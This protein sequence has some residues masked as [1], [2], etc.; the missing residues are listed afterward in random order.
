MPQLPPRMMR[1]GSRR[2]IVRLAI[3]SPDTVVGHLPK[4]PE[5]RKRFPESHTQSPPPFV[6]MGADIDQFLD[7]STNPS[8]FG[9]VPHGGIVAHQARKPDPF[10]HVTDE[11]ADAQHQRM[12]GE[13]P[14][15]Q[16]FEVQA[17]P[18]S[19]SHTDRDSSLRV[20]EACSAWYN[21]QAKGREVTN[22]R[23]SLSLGQLMF[24]RS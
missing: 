9:L 14:G 11:R 5:S 17:C 3:T 2:E 10:E 24:G 21:G 6:K 12:A 23:L 1:I 22:V 20:S 8:C 13:F 4:R 19:H 7:H 15:G 18:F 16:S